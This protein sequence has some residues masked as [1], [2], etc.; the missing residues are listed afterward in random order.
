LGYKS[1]RNPKEDQEKTKTNPEEITQKRVKRFTA[2]ATGPVKLHYKVWTKFRH[3]VC[4]LNRRIK[5]DLL[6]GH[7][8]A[9]VHSNK[10]YFYKHNG[11]ILCNYF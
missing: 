4:L 3:P 10:K 9:P 7:S 8:R 11:L 2:A 6:P 1:K 5:M